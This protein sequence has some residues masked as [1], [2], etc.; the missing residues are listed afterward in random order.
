MRILPFDATVIGISERDLFWV[1]EAACADC[2]VTLPEAM[3][4]RDLMP[5]V[6][7]RKP[8]IDEEYFFGSNTLLPFVI[9]ERRNDG[10]RVGDNI[11]FSRQCSFPQPLAGKNPAH[12]FW[13]DAY[14]YNVVRRCAHVQS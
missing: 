3:R 4:F 7:R 14:A 10:V 8:P 2:S 1:R 9:N 6:I 13:A 12:V 11:E 5:M